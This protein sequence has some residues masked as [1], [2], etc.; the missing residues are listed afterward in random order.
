[1][2]TTPKRL[3]SVELTTSAAAQY[4]A[5]TGV[6]TQIHACTITNND[7]SARTVSVWLVPSGGSAD[8]TNIIVKD[9]A[10][11][12]GQSYVVREALNHWLAAGGAIHASASANS[13]VTLVASGVEFT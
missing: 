8:D 2:A 3:C 13:A 5:G 1:M 10:L 6:S 11:N 12:V 9:R 4:T 7:S